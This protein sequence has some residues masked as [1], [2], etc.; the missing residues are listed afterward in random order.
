MVSS[1][2]VKVETVLFDERGIGFAGGIIEI[3]CR[4]F[5]KVGGCSPLTS[6]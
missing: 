3:E 1:A 5:I 6:E 4:A 2:V